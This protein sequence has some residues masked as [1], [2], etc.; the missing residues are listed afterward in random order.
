MLRKH[1]SFSIKES[2]KKISKYSPD[3]SFKVSSYFKE[4][5]IK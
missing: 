5:L 1:V 4:K 2:V 3:E